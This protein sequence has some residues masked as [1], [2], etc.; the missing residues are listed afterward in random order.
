MLLH[1]FIAL[2][3]SHEKYAVIF[4]FASLYMSFFSSGCFKDFLFI[5]VLNNLIMITC[6][7]TCYRKFYMF[8]ISE[9]CEILGSVALYFSSN[10]GILGM[11]HPQMFSLW[12][13]S[14]PQGLRL[15][16]Y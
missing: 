14:H 8:L 7:F 13:P 12:P 11:L 10:L 3:F 4:I 9:V 2:N 6:S 15:L 5:L 1:C 16:A